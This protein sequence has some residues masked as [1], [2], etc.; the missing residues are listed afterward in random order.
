M[1]QRKS[2][3]SV[4][5]LLFTFF[6]MSIDVSRCFPTFP[7]FGSLQEFSDSQPNLKSSSV[8]FA[9]GT[10]I[11]ILVVLAW[12]QESQAIV[13]WLCQPIFGHG[14]LELPVLL[15]PTF[16]TLWYIYI[17]IF[18]G[19]RA[20]LILAGLGFAAY[21]FY[22]RPRQEVALGTGGRLKSSLHRQYQSC[23]QARQ[24]LLPSDNRQI[25]WQ[26]FLSAMIAVKKQIFCHFI[27]R[28]LI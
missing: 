2:K 8:A 15:H 1:I 26:G 20:Q 16:G 3:K 24:Q 25:L 23:G 27:G 5:L 7:T 6:Y 13:T 19:L 12:P 11:T 21:K 17:Y 14:R 4:W 18:S 9:G 22:I 10:V 28:Q